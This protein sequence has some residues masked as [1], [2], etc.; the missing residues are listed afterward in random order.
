[1]EG[2]CDIHDVDMKKYSNEKGSWYAHK[3]QDGTWC[4]GE[5]KKEK[6]GTTR[7]GKYDTSQIR[8]KIW[9][10]A[11]RV[12]PSNEKERCDCIKQAEDYIFMGNVP[13]KFEYEG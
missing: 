4:H 7:S 8:C 12:F 3:T 11:W 10:I 2:Y 9:E 13:V 6:T 1:M 5:E